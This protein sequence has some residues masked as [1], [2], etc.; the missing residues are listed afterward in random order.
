MKLA[1]GRWVTGDD[2]FGR[3]A[4][5]RQLESQVRNRNPVLL[6]GQRRIGKTSKSNE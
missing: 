6:T 4:D 2:F 5:L 3:E 1:T